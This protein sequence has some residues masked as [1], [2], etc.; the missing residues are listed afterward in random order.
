MIAVADFPDQYANLPT[1]VRLMHGSE[2]YEVIGFWNSSSGNTIKLT[3]SR[4]EALLTTAAWKGADKVALLTLSAVGAQ[5]RVSEVYDSQPEIAKALCVLVQ[6]FEYPDW[7][8]L[9][10]L[11]V[12]AHIANR[13]TVP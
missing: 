13:R 1:S 2:G 11:E 10:M 8:H 4:W 6:G 3:P 9:T 12:I 7:S 5:T